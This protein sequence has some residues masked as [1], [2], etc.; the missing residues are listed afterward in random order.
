MSKQGNAYC[1][2]TGF[3]ASDL[4]VWLDAGTLEPLSISD[5]LGENWTDYASS[6][7]KNAETVSL[8]VYYR[9]M[10]YNVDPPV[11]KESIEAYIMYRVEDTTWGSEGVSIPVSEV[12]MEYIGEYEEF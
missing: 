6:S 3:V 12:N 2:T 11:E 7:V 8:T 9:E 5:I 4:A 10:D 1:L